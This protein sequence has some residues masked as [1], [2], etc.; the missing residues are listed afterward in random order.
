VTYT[1]F[2]FLFSEL[3]IL[4]GSLSN[5]GSLTAAFC[6]REPGAFRTVESQELKAPF[7]LVR[8]EYGSCICPIAILRGETIGEI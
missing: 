7:V 3:Q 4:V 5:K 8:K 6:S 1:Q 2:A